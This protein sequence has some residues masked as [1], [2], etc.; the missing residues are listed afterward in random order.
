MA[1]LNLAL[2]L[3]IIEKYGGQWRFAAAVGEHESAISK[4]LR[5]QRPLPDEKKRIWA[6]ALRCK[7]EEIFGVEK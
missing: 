1:P 4:V 6:K 7:P 2:K 5:Y 3:K